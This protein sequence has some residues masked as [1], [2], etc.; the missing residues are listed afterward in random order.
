M[1]KTSH[2]IP[3][4]AKNSDVIILIDEYVRKERDREILKEHWFEGLS[5]YQLAEKHKM[6]LTMVKKVIY[7]IG[8]KILLKLN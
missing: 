3:D 8:D 4:S 2:T 1:E 6:S 7:G 5:F